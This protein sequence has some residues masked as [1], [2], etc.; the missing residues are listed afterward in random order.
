MPQK[1]N[2]DVAELVRGK[3]GRVYGHLVGLLT[4]LKGLPLAYN[5]DMQED[6]EGLFDTVE[7]L[8]G[9]LELMAPM[10]ASMQVR[11][12]NMR[13][14]VDRDFSNATDLADYLVGK[15]IPFRQAH[16]IVGQ[17]VLHCINQQ[18]MLLDLSLDE[19]RQFSEKIDSDVFAAL[20]IERVVDA[21]DVYGG[22]A[23]G[24]VEQVIAERKAQIDETLAWLEH[25]HKTS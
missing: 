22:P 15:G 7:T 3:T 1:K 2:P 8:S 20:D 9:A 10:I 13:A 19:Y 5:K 12:E 21:R 25:V 23:R 17:A 11:R 24:Q 16:E 6:K 4:V 18:K 14:A